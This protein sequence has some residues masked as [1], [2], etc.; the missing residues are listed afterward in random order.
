MPA[1]TEQLEKWRAW[2]IKIGAEAI[3]INRGDPRF[4]KKMGHGIFRGW[5]WARSKGERDNFT[6]EWI[7]SF[8]RRPLESIASLYRKMGY[9]VELIWLIEK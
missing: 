1:S 4:Y 2:G 7:D 3:F 6:V 8:E 5:H 9:E